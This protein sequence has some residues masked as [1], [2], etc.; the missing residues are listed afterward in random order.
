[1]G[2]ILP[3]L[4]VIPEFFRV[5]YCEVVLSQGQGNEN[6]VASSPS[7]SPFGDALSHHPQ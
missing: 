1:M 5:R 6:A 2:K 7:T 4:V 3:I